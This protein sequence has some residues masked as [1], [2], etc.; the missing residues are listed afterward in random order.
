MKKL[1]LIPALC[2]FVLLPCSA[3]AWEAEVVSV[4]DGD[5]L[6]VKTANGKKD[7]VRLWGIDAPELQQK[8]GKKAQK[9]LEALVLG[10]SVEVQEVARDRYA[11][12]LA[13]VV[14]TDG[15]N[16]GISA[17]ELM[18][19]G[20]HAWARGSN[21]WVSDEVQ[22]RGEGAGLWKEKRPLE[23]WK[24]RKLNPKK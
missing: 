9:V 17:N 19:R 3:Q 15:D 13:I 18:V 7:R 2:L 12:L 10:R 20:G 22:A 8:H 11:R 24:W 14:I 4:Y 23:P 5:S 1:L 21:R 6:T 16:V